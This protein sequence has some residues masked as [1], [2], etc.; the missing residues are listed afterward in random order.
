[1]VTRKHFPYPLMEDD[2]V[3][4][5]KK[6]KDVLGCTEKH[7]YYRFQQ[8]TSGIP[9]EWRAATICLS[10]SIYEAHR[11]AQASKHANWNAEETAIVQ[12]H[13]AVNK[14]VALLEQLAERGT[15]VE[16]LS[17]DEIACY[18]EVMAAA[19]LATIKVIK[20][21]MARREWTS[22][23]LYTPATI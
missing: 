16:T 1:M 3:E 6:I 8:K 17:P 7:V 11:F 5:A 20:L 13:L 12:M 10:R 18:A 4:G 23:T 19:A 14:A 2:F 21:L 15:P 9:F 22:G